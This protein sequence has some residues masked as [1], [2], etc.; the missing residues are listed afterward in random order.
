MV[1][2]G[3]AFSVAGP[4]GSRVGYTKVSAAKPAKLKQH[5]ET[6]RGKKASKSKGNGSSGAE[7]EKKDEMEEGGEDDDHQ[8]SG[9]SGLDGD[10]E[11]SEGGTGTGE[12]RGKGRWV[13]VPS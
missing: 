13:H 11:G 3:A 7:Q 4:R 12:S 8:Q 6:D 5:K 2:D 9:R 10:G 1:V